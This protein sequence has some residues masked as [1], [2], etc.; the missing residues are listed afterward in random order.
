MRS[1]LLKNNGQS[2]V[3]ALIAG[4]IGLVITMAIASMLVSQMRETKYLEQKLASLDLEK[5]LITTLADGSVC[6][7]MLTSPGPQFFNSTDLAT[8]Q[9]N[10][11]RIPA[12]TAVTAPDLITTT[13]S[14]GNQLSA[15]AIVVNSISPTGTPDL[16]L[17]KIE[18]D[19]N[20]QNLMRAIKPITLQT[21]LQT[22]STSPVTA[23]RITS[24][25]KA[26]P[27]AL[28]PI[29]VYGP[30]R[31]RSVMSTAT[32]PAGYSLVTGGHEWKSDCGCA[33]NQRFTVI[34]MP[35]PDGKSWTEWMECSNHRA[36]A[37][38]RQD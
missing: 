38:C 1:V 23:K 18:I 5:L 19:F 20:S 29:I 26:A 16:W 27:A 6:Q 17:A 15:T 37:L 4:A 33:E 22:D 12:S 25:V 21:F 7:K 36:V 13:P 32:C 31:C 30:I 14:P 11:T 8:Q 34:S 3:Q 28:P 10:L 35:L 9:I 2:I 24:C